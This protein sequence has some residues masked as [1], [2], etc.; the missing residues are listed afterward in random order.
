MKITPTLQGCL[1]IDI[2]SSVDWARI[3]MICIDA[4]KLNSL[5]SVTLAEKMTVEADWKNYVMPD[6]DAAFSE[7]TSTIYSLIKT[8]RSKG[9]ENG[10]IH[11]T[12]EQCDLWYGSLNQ[13]RIALEN[14][15]SLSAHDESE[16][17]D[18]NKLPKDTLSAYM[19][20]RFYLILQTNLLDHVYTAW[21]EVY[22]F[23]PA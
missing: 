4:S 12:P 14:K 5:L 3:E 21:S 2:E 10:E 17:E 1:R 6:L 8:S 7:Q 16:F 19:R 9:S 20:S 13:A 11:I 15:Y 22:S 18:L 23:H